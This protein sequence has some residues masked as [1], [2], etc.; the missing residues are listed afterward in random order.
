MLA[1]ETQLGNKLVDPLAPV[2]DEQLEKVKHLVS[3]RA[4]AGETVLL[5]MGPQHGTHGALH[6]LL[7]LDAEKIVSCVPYIGYLHTGIE[8]SCENQTYTKIIPITERIDGLSPLSN[9]LG[10][11]MAVEKLLG[12]PERVPI[13]AQYVRVILAELSRIASHLVWLGTCGLDIGAVRVFRNALCEREHILDILEMCSGQRV[14]SS[15]FRVGGLWRDVPEDF[16]PAVRQFLSFI[17]DKIR[18]HERLLKD[19][20]TWKERSVGIG[21]INS[22]Q[23]IAWGLG[24]PCLRASGVDWDLR[25]V[26]PYSC[27]EHFTFNVPLGNNGDAYDRYLCRSL[28]LWQSLRIIQQALDGLPGGPVM[29]KDRK[30]APPPKEELAYSMEA[31]I[32][33]FKLWTAGFCP[34]KG[35]IYHAIESP[36]GEFGVYINSDGSS[37]PRRIHFRTPAFAS[38]QALP[39]MAKGL[40]LAGLVS[41]VSSIDL[42]M[43]E[44][45]R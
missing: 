3:S 1:N 42:L 29:I 4:L 25:K 11:V 43:G 35:E 31:L 40:T 8:K 9:N 24:G 38:L 22:Q 45:D 6:L 5:N 39:V 27:Y 41:T 14:I 15:Y 32:H 16:E 30:I 36:R 7:E 21:V 34:P 23:A 17:P 20:P 44:V 2:K 13:R 26:A 33:H 28:E 10:Y 18:E 12:I 37:K 19:N